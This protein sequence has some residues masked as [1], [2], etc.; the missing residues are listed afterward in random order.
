LGI[1]PG[2]FH[3]PT[4]A[5]LG[6]AKAALAFVDEVVFVMPRAFPH[7]EYEAVGIQQRLDLLAAAAG[8]EP[9]F[10]VAV[11]ERG[12]FADIARECRAAYG[13]GPNCG[14]FAGRDAPSVP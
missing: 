8:D 13:P 14:F 11:T 2:A 5:H 9:R 1:F 4:R 7:K 12:L 6:I 3:P 10:S